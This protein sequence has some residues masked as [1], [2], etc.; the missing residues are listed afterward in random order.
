MMVIRKFSNLKAWARKAA[1]HYAEKRDGV[2]AIEF[3]FVAPVMIA[4]YFGM[5]EIALGIGADREVAHTASVVGDLATQVSVVNQNEMESIM[6]AALTVLGVQPE[7]R[8][9]VTVEL[10]SYQM[11]TDGSGTID[12]IGY[13]RM[14]PTISA[15]GPAT[16]DPNSVA[17]M[18][19]E[20]S[21]VVVARV[22]Y[23]YEPKTMKFVENMTLAETFV[24]KPRKSVA[25]AFDEGG[26]TTFTC[27]A[28]TD[29]SATCVAS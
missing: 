15:G 24:L 26:A 21:G 11:R 2:A 18:M 13:A 27:T 7:K 14:G 23:K 17:D 1:H 3:A 12:L 10:N 6:T 28:N 25:V 29:L 8:A 4:F 16:F 5:S 20:S 9:G 22:N 19:S